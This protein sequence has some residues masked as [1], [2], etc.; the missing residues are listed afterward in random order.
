MALSGT[1]NGLPIGPT[2]IHGR[3]AGAVLVRNPTFTLTFTHPE[4]VNARE[5]YTL[6]VTVTNTSASPANFVSVN[7]FP[8]NISGA[9][10]ND[11]SSKSVDEIAP[12]DS[13]TV[14]FNLIS[15]R[16]GKV[17]AATLD[18]AEQVQGRFVLKTAI[19]ELGAPLSPDSLVLPPEASS[20]SSGLRQA[21]VDLLAR[22]WAVA[23]AP[24]AALPKDL[25]RFS[26]QVV[27]D[28]GV[29]T[30]EAGLRVSLGDSMSRS[31]SALLF[32]FLGTE[33]TQLAKKVPAGDTTGLL[34]ALLWSDASQS[35]ATCLPMRLPRSS[36]LRCWR[37]ALERFS[38]R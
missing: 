3:A 24:P 5:P 35:E 18:S 34:G 16:T 4:V 27:L 13:K 21:A 26:K 23:T 20:L 29:E 25:I 9:T 31:A 37:G 38:R 28:R 33:F 15:Q 6:D 2:P 7:L 19:G 22:A 30:A 36:R 32:D 1:L 8:A 12:G 11:D 17:T 10:L 14:T